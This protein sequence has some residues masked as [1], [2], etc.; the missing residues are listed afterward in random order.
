M[1]KYNLLSVSAKSTARTEEITIVGIAG[2]IF[3]KIFSLTPTS[4]VKP[5]AC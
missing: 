2:I 3:L 1:A 4:P 5:G